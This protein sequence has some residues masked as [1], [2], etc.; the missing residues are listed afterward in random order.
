[1]ESEVDC[2]RGGSMRIC[3]DNEP[4]NV[5]FGD[6]GF[7]SRRCSPRNQFQQSV[8][9][10]VDQGEP[11]G[12]LKS[13]NAHPLEVRQVLGAAYHTRQQKIAC[14]LHPPQ[15]LYLRGRDYVFSTLFSFGI[16]GV[17]SG[18]DPGLSVFSSSYLKMSIPPELKKNKAYNGY[19]NCLAR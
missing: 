4:N 6:D 11:M 7:H 2:I 19:L 1:M 9:Q 8:C 13:P 17:I 10:L 3:A 16:F 18:S 14:W 15:E 12:P 5:Y